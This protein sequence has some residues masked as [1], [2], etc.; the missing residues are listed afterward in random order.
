MNTATKS[1][2]R[3]VPWNNGKLL[4]QKPPLKL[5]E[6][7]AIRIRLQVDHRTRGMRLRPGSPWRT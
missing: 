7:W 1:E 2:R 5:K 6:I 3:A 4:G